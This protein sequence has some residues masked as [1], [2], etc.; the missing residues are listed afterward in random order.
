[1]HSKETIESYFEMQSCQWPK[2]VSFSSIFLGWSAHL[3]VPKHLTLKVWYGPTY[4][5]KAMHNL[6]LV[7]VSLDND[8]WVDSA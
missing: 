6:F 7:E 1:M 2:F 5:L 8:H 4:Q 3:N